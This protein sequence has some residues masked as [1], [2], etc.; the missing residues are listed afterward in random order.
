MCGVKVGFTLGFGGE[1]DRERQHGKEQERDR[2]WLSILRDK[3]S[4]FMGLPILLDSPLY[5][6]EFYTTFAT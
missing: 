2:K 3:G 6:F 1:L 5:V 4:Q